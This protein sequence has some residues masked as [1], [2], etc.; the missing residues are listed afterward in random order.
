[1]SRRSDTS[2]AAIAAEAWGVVLEVAMG[3]RDR[4][5]AALSEFGLTPGDLRALTALDPH[6]SR[7]MGSLAA[8]WDC[9]A[10][11][12]T[13]MI[14]RLEQRGLV[15]RRTHPTDRRAKTVALTPLGMQTKT[16][17]ITRL[18][19]PPADLLSLDR[20]TL[21]TL[22]TALAKLPASLRA[23]RRPADTVKTAHHAT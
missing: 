8:A 20:E 16:D 22:R 2:K 18:H 17:L 23:G 5:L 3:Q 9:D 10:S 13:W 19:Q 1:M 15:E 4:F 11:N 21:R 14:D 12:V 7:P 6:H